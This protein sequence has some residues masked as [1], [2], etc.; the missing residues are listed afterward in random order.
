MFL[1]TLVL[2]FCSKPQWLLISRRGKVLRM[3]CKT[4]TH[5]IL[6]THTHTHKFCSHTH[7]HTHTILFPAVAA[8]F[9]PQGLSTSWHVH[10]LVNN[11][12]P[13]LISLILLLS[14]CNFSMRLSPTTCLKL[15]TP[16]SLFSLIVL[17]PTWSTDSWPFSKGRLVALACSPS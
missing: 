8:V 2:K 16:F 15:Q 17:L 11:T 1:K 4:H 5:T 10:S 6:F 14:R 13:S 7:T 12:A 3:D 9:R